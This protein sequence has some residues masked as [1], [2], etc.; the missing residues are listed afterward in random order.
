MKE[1]SKYKTKFKQNG[2]KQNAER[3]EGITKK[4]QNRY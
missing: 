4:I 1:K 2:G 3:K